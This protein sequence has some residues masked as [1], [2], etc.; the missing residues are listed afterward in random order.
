MFDIN[1][2]SG[3]KKEEG[4]WL[5]YETGS[6]LIASGSKM[7]FQKMLGKLQQPY[8]RKIDKGALDPKISQDILCKCLAKHIL[9][10]WKNVGS[11]GEEIPY[12]EE[13]AYKILVNNDGLRNW[14]SD[15]SLDLDNF[16]QENLAS[17]GKPSQ[18]D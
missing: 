6:F 12:T 9:L 2:E 16:K 18:S 7:A 8:V 4:V 14:V 15:Q 10:G 17:E 1:N 5:D 13:V 11:N 3:E